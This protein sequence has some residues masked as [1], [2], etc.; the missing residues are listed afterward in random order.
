[1]NEETL[2]ELNERKE[3]LIKRYIGVWSKPKSYYSCMEAIDNSI[4]KLNKK[5]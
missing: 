2:E 5:A 3:A 1:M 4:A